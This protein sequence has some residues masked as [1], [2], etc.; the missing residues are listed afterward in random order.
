M[1]I[2]LGIQKLRPRGGLEDHCLRIAAELASRGQEVTLFTSVKED[3]PYKNVVLKPPFP[4]F[5]NHGMVRA[6]ATQFIAASRGQFDRTVA[7]QPAPGADVLFIADTLR[8]RSDAPFLQRLTPRFRVRRALE[9]GCFGA[10]AR[11]RIIGLAENQMRA[12]VERFPSSSN[13][14]AIIPPSLSPSRRRPG[15]R[16]PEYRLAARQRLD[17]DPSSKVWLWLGL[18]P[19]VK[20][21]DRVI[22]ALAARPDVV[23]LV[24][25][26]GS[27]NRKARESIA[28]AA[29]R[30]I[31]GRLRW[32]GYVSE[33]SYFDAIAAA[34][35]LA[36][37]AR[38]DVTGGVILEAIVNGLPVVAT[39]ICGFAAHIEASGA[40][41][42]VTSPFSAE[43]FAA[44]L[45]FVTESDGATMS[46]RGIAYGADPSLYSGIEAACDLIEAADWPLPGASP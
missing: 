4:T 43:A 19:A 32:L 30:G 45:D 26:L 37:P 14:I 35:L 2:A 41:R 34:D 44:A 27:A 3:C 6:F 7:F 28:R 24:G 13:R 10:E 15:L 12:F 39:D 20:G 36:H 25:G 5:S 40:G 11:T 23:L 31:G 29:R 46:A 17:L 16:A 1:R 42:I 38:L 33:E 21:L 18:Q 8:S 22:D 9:E